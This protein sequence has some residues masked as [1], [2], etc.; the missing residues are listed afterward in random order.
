MI[1]LV[2]KS[3]IQFIYIIIEIKYIEYTSIEKESEG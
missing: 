3:S 1:P 2:K